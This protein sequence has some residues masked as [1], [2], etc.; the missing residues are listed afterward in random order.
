[1]RN[2]KGD[3]VNALNHLEDFH[4][5]Q[6][7]RSPGTITVEAD[8]IKQFAAQFDPQP[9]HLDEQAA[10]QSFFRGLAASGWHTAALTMRLL[11]D[12]LHIQGGL[13]GAGF[14]EFRWPR[15]TRPGDVL[16]LE[17]EVLAIQTSQSKPKQ[18]FLNH[19]V[20]TY[21]QHD[22]PVLIMTGNLLVPRRPQG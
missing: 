3:A 19:R 10:Q 11:V 7:F 5:G 1:M 15:P 18:G 4:P 8:A 13:I 6:V 22:E 17:A 16:R 2:A 14:D 21:N 9:F 12:T 20:T